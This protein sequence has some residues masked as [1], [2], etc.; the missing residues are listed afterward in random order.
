MYNYIPT[1]NRFGEQNKAME[2]NN[3]NNYF[4]TANGLISGKTA[5]FMIWMNKKAGYNGD[6]SIF[7]LAQSGNPN[8]IYL[9]IS[10]IYYDNI[11]LGTSN[12][13]S[14]II[15]EEWYHISLVMELNYIKIYLDGI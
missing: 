8:L 10:Y 12:I 7:S 3:I 4:K 9:N 15:D 14:K 5:T 1:K 6:P 13:K 11:Y 2:I